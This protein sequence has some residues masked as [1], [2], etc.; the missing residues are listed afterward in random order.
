MLTCQPSI[1]TDLVRHGADVNAAD[2]NGHTALHLA[3]KNA[4]VEDIR[5]LREGMCNRSQTIPEDG[6]ESIEVNLRNFEGEKPT[7]WF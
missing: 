1:V 6:G 5:A 3:C 2:R 4:D 7:W